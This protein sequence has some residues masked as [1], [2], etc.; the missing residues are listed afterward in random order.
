MA[1]YI[2][3]IIVHEPKQGGVTITDEP[4]WSS[5]TGRGSDGVMAGHIVDWKTTIAITWPP[6]SFAEAKKIIDAVKAGGAFFTLK[7]N[8]VYNG[9][10]TE[11]SKTVYASNVPRSLYSLASGKKLATDTTIT[12]IEK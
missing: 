8:D 9:G 4:V 6:L 1:F 3:G 10:G 7:Y 11:V 5:N 12:F 2:N